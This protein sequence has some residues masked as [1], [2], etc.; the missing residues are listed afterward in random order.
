[1]IASLFRRLRGPLA[2]GCVAVLALAAGSALAGSG[3]GGV[4]N[5]GQTNT[6]DAET[7]LNGN[8]GGNPQLRVQNSSGGSGAFGV[9]G[10]ITSGSP[11]TQSAGLRGM[12]SGTTANGYGVWGSHEGAGTGVYG[13]SATTGIGVHGF[14]PGEYFCTP[15]PMPHCEWRGK[16]VFGDTDD[17]F[18]IYGHSGGIGYAGSF[19]GR[20]TVTDSVT[21]GPTSAPALTA[22]SNTG[23][24]GVTGHSSSGAGVFGTS[25][26]GRGVLGVNSATARTG[27]SP[28]VYGSATAEDGVWAISD[29]ATGIYAQGKNYAAYLNGRVFVDRSLSLGWRTFGDNDATPDVHNG[30]LFRVSNSSATV[31]T[32]FDNGRDGQQLTLRFTNSNTDVAD[33]SSIKLA[34]T[35]SPSTDDTLQLVSDS[36]IWYE[37]GRSSN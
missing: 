24:A 34:G 6:V 29:Q 33:N 22:S 14:V 17:G 30:S 32:N 26:S 27:G 35:F 20:V 1:M 18:A 5:L 3:V 21:I 23:N 11:S 4:F 7:I 19:D 36:G 28:G 25:A 9:L 13:S 2:L 31:V 15:P 8:A 37:T 10:R 12:N 16:A